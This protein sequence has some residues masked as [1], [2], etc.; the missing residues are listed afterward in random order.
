MFGGSP[1][2]RDERALVSALAASENREH[3]ENA[4]LAICAATYA[5][6][7]AQAHAFV[8]GNKRLA[9]AISEIFLE[10]NGSVL[11]ATNQEI[12]TLFLEIAA[13]TLTREDVEAFFKQRTLRQDK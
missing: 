6:H 7:L 5:C 13:G 12:V 4:D 3:Y 9:A 11:D 2:L 1:G 8:D 10:I